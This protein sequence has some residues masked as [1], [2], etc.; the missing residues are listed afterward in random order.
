MPEANSA[1]T[2]SNPPGLYPCIAPQ[3]AQRPKLL[4]RSK[5]KT[6]MTYAHVLNPGPAGVRSPVDGL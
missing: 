1:P 4:V 6:T 3:P 5:V 2:L